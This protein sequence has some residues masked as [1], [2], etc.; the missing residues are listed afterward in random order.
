[1]TAY[2]HV[3]ATEGRHQVCETTTG[4]D[5]RPIPSAAF[6][7]PR[8]AVTY[9]SMRE[10]RIQPLRSSGEDPGSP[11]PEGLGSSPE[12]PKGSSPGLTTGT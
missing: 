10:A 11:P 9:A 3:H 4:L 6:P 8:A 2:F 7:T 12:Q 5:H 1:M